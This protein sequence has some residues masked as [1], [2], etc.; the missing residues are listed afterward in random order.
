MAR[1]DFVDITY[2]IPTGT[3]LHRLQV[4]TVGGSLNIDESKTSPFIKV[5]TLDRTGEPLETARFAKSE[6]V[7]IVEGHEMLKPI[8]PNR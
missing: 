3:T 5:E 6:V 2:R 1:G 4:M 8:R 7:A